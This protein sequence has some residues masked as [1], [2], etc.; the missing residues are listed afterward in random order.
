MRWLMIWCFTAG[1][2]H[3]REGCPELV[4]TASLSRHISEADMAFSTMDEQAFRTARWTAQRAIPCLGEPI[5]AGQAAAYYR[6]EALGSFVDQ[7]HA[8]TVGFFKSML[9]VAPH[10]LL[11]EAMAPDGH[12]LR[13]NF[14]V[15]QGTMPVEGD[16]VQ[17]AGDGVIRI[18]GRVGTEFPKDRPYLFQ[19]VSDSGIVLA[20]TVVGIGVAPP[21]YGT[22]RGIQNAH[23]GRGQT[24]AKSEKRSPSPIQVNVPLASIAG[25]AAAVAGISYA[26][27]VSSETKFWDPTTK[28][29]NL[30]GLKKKTNTMVWVS[31]ISGTVALGTGVSAFLVGEF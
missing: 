16:P 5:Q 11:P 17:R 20:S 10:Y 25:G 12:P 6:M 23:A 26:L 14:E 4:S 13:V 19:H 22:M 3:A 24:K 18:D 9:R 27:A 8:Q 21:R 30:D 2:A 28:R 31:G 7:H 15:A 29:S 1:L